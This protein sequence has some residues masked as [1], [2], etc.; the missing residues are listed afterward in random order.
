MMN[1]NPI[2]TGQT[3]PQ[4][5]QQQLQQSMQQS[6]ANTGIIGQITPRPQTPINPQAMSNQGT[7]NAMFGQSMPGTF[8]RNVGNG[9]L[10][11]TSTPGQM[12]SQGY[13]PGIDPTNAS[14]QPDINAVTTAQT[15]VPLTPP[16]G[17]QQGGVTPYYD[18]SN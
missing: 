15:G 17:V 4:S 9:P 18:L 16:T 13:I 6:M 12:T 1:F 8:N 2:P 7:I 11:Q 5:L 3:S 14:A 10:M